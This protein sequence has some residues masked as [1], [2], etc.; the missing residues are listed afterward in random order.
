MSAR[1]VAE[2]VRA[3]SHTTNVNLDWDEPSKVVRMEVDEQ[4]RPAA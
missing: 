1:E 2:K 3:N 4:G